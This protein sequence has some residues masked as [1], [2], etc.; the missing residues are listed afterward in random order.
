MSTVTNS[1]GTNNF[2][3]NVMKGGTLISYEDALSNHSE[4]VEVATQSP[5]LGYQLAFGEGEGL[6]VDG[7]LAQAGEAAYFVIVAG[8]EPVRTLDPTWVQLPPEPIAF[9]G[10]RLEELALRSRNWEE[11]TDRLKLAVERLRKELDA[12]TVQNLELKGT[13][14]KAQEDAARFS[15]QLDAQRMLPNRDRDEVA[16]RV[17]KL[18]ARSE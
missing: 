5:V 11:R 10:G 9:N 1:F 13:L 17:R 12:Q 15:A 2:N 14:E 8:H 6:Q 18:E 4:H 3:W 16:I 7:T